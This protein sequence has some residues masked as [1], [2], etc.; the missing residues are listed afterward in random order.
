MTTQRDPPKIDLKIDS[1][2][3]QPVLHSSGGGGAAGERESAV[4]LA[5]LIAGASGVRLGTYCVDCKGYSIDDNILLN[6]RLV[7]I[8]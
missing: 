4:A 2:L 5:V 3:I 1:G 8:R 7:L 6:P